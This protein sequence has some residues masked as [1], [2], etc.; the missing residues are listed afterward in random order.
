MAGELAPL[1]EWV[2]E[3]TLWSMGLYPLFNKGLFLDPQ[4]YEKALVEVFED[5]TRQLI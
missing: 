5:S 2:D 3:Y 4:R 1:N